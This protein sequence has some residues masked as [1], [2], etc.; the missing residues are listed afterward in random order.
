VSTV[1]EPGVQHLAQEIDILRREN[2]ALLRE[3]ENAYAQLTAVLQ[4]SQDE[5][6]IAYS[7]L[8]E[9]LVVQ[10][11]KLVE[12]AMLSSASEALLDESDLGRLSR[13]VVDKTCLLLPT[14]LV[15]LQLGRSPEMAILR[16]RDLVREVALDRNGAHSLAELSRAMEAES[17]ATLLVQDLE[18]E[19]RGAWLRQRPDAR[20]AAALALRSDGQW[21]GLLVLNSR[22]RANF[23]DD[24]EPLLA[25]FA[26][27]AA[28]ALGGALR[29]QRH[30]DLVV[31]VAAA[32]G[33]GAEALERCAQAGQPPADAAVLHHVLARC[34]ETA[35]VGAPLA[36]RHNESET[37]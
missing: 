8:Q 37:R 22:L 36:V 13:L 26:H 31:Q 20:S 30:R 28:A 24:Q 35:E 33:L 29:L 7:E 16:E 21:L 17:R 25:A 4:V 2:E 27:Q 18:T 5:T 14:D 23:R 19:P 34:L 1:N 10:E 32:G 6:R 12:L 9:K 15:L 3:L 11:M